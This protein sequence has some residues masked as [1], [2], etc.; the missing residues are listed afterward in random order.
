[1]PQI[2]DTP[3]RGGGHMTQTLSNMKQLHL[4]T[5]QMA[6]DGEFTTNS[7]LGWPGDTGGT[8]SN[9]TTQLVHGGYLSTNDLA[10]LLSA[11]GMKVPTNTIPLT[12]HTALIVYAVKANS[13]DDALFL[14]TANF[15]YTPTG[16]VYDPSAEPYPKKGFITFRKAGD[17]AILTPR[18]ANMTNIIGS[19]VP[20]CP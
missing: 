16:G 6:L 7:A 14:S 1:M 5:Q 15:T 13:P 8:F 10:K 19:Y 9:W 12:N 17:G 3:V 20:I 2:T 4:A 18:Q 11:P